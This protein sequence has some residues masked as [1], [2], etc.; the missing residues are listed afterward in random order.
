MSNAGYYRQRKLRT[1]I[2]KVV[3]IE[4]GELAG[5]TATT[6]YNNGIPQFNALCNAIESR[7]YALLYSIALHWGRKQVCTEVEAILVTRKLVTEI[8]IACRM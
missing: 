3:C 7:Y 1:V 4:T 6:Y 8:A 2:G 5:G